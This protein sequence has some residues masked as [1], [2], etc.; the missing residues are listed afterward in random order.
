M[1]K[2]L[3]IEKMDKG[4]THITK[5]VYEQEDATILW[6][7]GVQSERMRECE[8]ERERGRG[9]EKLGK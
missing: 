8:R 4:Y 9:R 2:A 5:P 1:C 3:G 7:Q 6:N